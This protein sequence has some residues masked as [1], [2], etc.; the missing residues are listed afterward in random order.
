MPSSGTAVSEICL[1]PP[2][3]KRL[4]LDYT[5]SR[6]YCLWKTNYSRRRC[7]AFTYW[8]SGPVRPSYWFGSR[9][10]NRP[11]AIQPWKQRRCSSAIS[12]TYM[13]R[14]AHVRSGKADENMLNRAHLHL[15]WTR[16]ASHNLLN[17]GP[18]LPSLGLCP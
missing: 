1:S 12:F 6:Y 14:P 9:S 3:V 8:Q 2:T 16:A 13:R 10:L 4:S 18:A 11:C 17:L 15:N 7:G 5:S